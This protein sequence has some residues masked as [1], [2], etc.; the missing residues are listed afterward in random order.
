MKEF[1]KEQY[2]Y[3]KRIILC[4]DYFRIQSK[5]TSCNLTNDHKFLFRNYVLYINC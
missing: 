1:D 2:S 5:I 3:R 4:I